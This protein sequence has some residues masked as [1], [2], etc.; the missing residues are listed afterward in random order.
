MIILALDLSTSDTGFSIFDSK[1]HELLKYGDI[2]GVG[3]DYYEKIEKM[4]YR[5]EEI[6]EAEK[7]EYIVFEDSFVG[8]KNLQSVI[9]LN[10]L[11]GLVLSI[12]FKKKIPFKSIPPKVIKKF[13]TENGSASKDLVQ[14]VVNKKFNLEIK[15]DN[16][17]DAIAIG[18]TFL[19]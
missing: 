18:Y 1:T 7:I 11:A 3:E 8:F 19:G 10:R 4:Y 9:K 17:S 5:I 2:K 14:E 6:V 12:C 15:N 13:V 16:I